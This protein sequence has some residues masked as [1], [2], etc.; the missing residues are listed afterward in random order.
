MFRLSTILSL[1]CKVN[2]FLRQENENMEDL[3]NVM[4]YGSLFGFHRQQEHLI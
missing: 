2:D 1:E 4:D 3:L